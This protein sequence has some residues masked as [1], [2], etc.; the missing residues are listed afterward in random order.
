MTYFEKIRSLNN[1]QLC[2]FLNEIQGDLELVALALDMASN[3]ELSCSDDDFCIGTPDKG[4][5]KRYDNTVY[6]HA[7]LRKDFD[8][9]MD[10]IFKND[11]E[12][13]DDIRG[14]KGGDNK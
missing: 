8:K 4:E 13:R 2:H 5:T 3:P 14:Y 9:T 12:T 10:R 11:K 1:L 6:W 7:C